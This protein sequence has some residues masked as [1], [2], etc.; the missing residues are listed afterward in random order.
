[1]NSSPASVKISKPIIHRLCSPFR[2]R[3]SRKIRNIRQSDARWQHAR[4]DTRKTFFGLQIIWIHSSE[5]QCCIPACLYNIK[6]KWQSFIT[7]NIFKFLKLWIKSRKEYQRNWIIFLQVRIDLYLGYTLL[8]IEFVTIITHWAHN[9]H[10]YIFMIFMI[11]IELLPN[12]RINVY[13]IFSNQNGKS[14]P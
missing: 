7:I 12:F 6:S 13:G 14:P 1:M 8:D 10:V 11:H 9:S 5:I 2:F 3:T 4:Y